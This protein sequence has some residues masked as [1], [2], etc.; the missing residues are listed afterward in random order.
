MSIALQQ[1][2]EAQIGSVASEDRLYEQLQK[3]NELLGEQVFLQRVLALGA[4]KTIRFQFEHCEVALW[5][6]QVT[7]DL[8]QRRILAGDSF[9]KVGVL[10][11]LRAR[12][13]KDAV[14]CDVGAYIGNQAIYFAKCAGASRVHAFEVLDFTADVLRRNVSLNA[15]GSRIIVENYAIGLNDARVKLG[16]FKGSNIGATTVQQSPDGELTSRSLDSMTFGRLDLLS[17]DIGTGE[18]DALKG[19]ENTILQHKPMILVSLFDGETRKLL[20]GLGM[21]EVER[22]G[23]VERLF[24]F[25]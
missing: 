22:L 10:N 14:I 20:S 9:F 24:A 21:S 2:I 5:L 17:F 11:R 13:P 25:Q 6:P 15:L 19:A 3:A 7:S 23:A 12:L 4:E 16:P 18:Y 1:Y 8:I